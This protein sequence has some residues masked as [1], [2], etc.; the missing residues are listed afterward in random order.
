MG[1]PGG[2]YG[3]M[4][5]PGR[6]QTHRY[7]V[8]ATYTKC[9]FFAITAFC[10][11]LRIALARLVAVPPTA[12]CVAITVSFFFKMYISFVFLF[13]PRLLPLFYHSEALKVLII[14][15]VI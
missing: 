14:D 12:D 6:R 11:F 4:P 1:W 8:K 13:T 9:L 5:M 7:A 2:L 15:C 3:P 10:T